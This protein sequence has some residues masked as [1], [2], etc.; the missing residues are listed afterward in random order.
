MIQSASVE[1]VIETIR[2]VYGR[3]TRETSIAAMREDWDALFA[4][5][6]APWPRH[7]VDAGGVPAEW[8]VPPG[9]HTARTILYLH[10]GGFRLGSID[11]HRDL[12]QRLALA[13]NAR[14]LAV[15]YRL[16]SRAPL[17]RRAHRCHPG[18]ELAFEHN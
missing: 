13:A 3:W 10:G 18:V 12:M 1:D 17:P 7:C 4:T 11:S 9:I 6:A 8:I 2:A 16:Y 15:A 5:R 14:I